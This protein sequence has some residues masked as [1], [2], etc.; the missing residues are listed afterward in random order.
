MSSALR[1]AAPPVPALLLSL[2]EPL[3]TGWGAAPLGA[4]LH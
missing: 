2:Y 1:E 4:E 3:R